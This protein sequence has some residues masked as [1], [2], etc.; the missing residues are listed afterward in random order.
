MTVR[1]DISKIYVGYFG[2]SPEPEGFN[3]WISEANRGFTALETAASFSVQPEST[4]R[5]PYLSN[6]NVADPGPFVDSVY[7]NLFNRDPDPEGR[8]FWIGELNAAQGNPDAV[9]A[10]ILN[11]IS[12]AQNTEEFGPDLDIINNKVKVALDWAESTAEIPGFVYEFGSE[13]ETSAKGVLDDV[14]ETQTSVD[15]G[16]AETDAFIASGAGQPVNTI[17]LTDEIDS[18]SDFVGTSGADQFNATGDT[19]NTGDDLNGGGGADTLSV[20]AGLFQSIVATP[21]LQAIENIEVQGGANN[22]FAQLDLTTSSGVEMAMLN[23]VSGTVQ[24]IGVQDIISANVTNSSTPTPTSP[25]SGTT[26]LSIAYNAAAVAGDADVQ[27]LELENSGLA[28]LSIAG[29]ETV[30]VTATGLNFVAEFD[31]ARELMVDGTGDLIA[32][33]TSADTSSTPTATFDSTAS[34]GNM[35]ISFASGQQVVASAGSGNDNFDLTNTT[36]VNVSGGAGDDIF[37]FDSGNGSLTSEDT[38]DGGEGKDTLAVD[39]DTAAPASIV[40]DVAGMEVLLFQSAFGSLVASEYTQIDEFIFNGGPNNGRVNITGVE[41]DDTFI[42]TSDQGNSDQTLR[43]EGEN[44]G[45]SLSMELHALENGSLTRDFQTV[46]DGNVEVT[47]NTNSGNDVSAIFLAQNIGSVEIASTG[48]NVA[49][50]VIEAI[51]TGSENY[52]AF[53]NDNGTSSFSI[54]GE[55][56]LTIT[57]REGVSL[58]GSSDTLGF[59][60]AVNLDAGAFTGNLRI[61]LSNSADVFEGGSGDDIIYTMGG[62]DRVTGG[63]GSDQFRYSNNSGTDVILDFLIGEDMIGLSEVDFKNTTETTAG[64]TL[65][66][67]DYVENRNGIDNIGSADDFKML[68]LQTGLSADQITNDTGADVEAYVLVYNTTTDKGEIW[69]DND[70]STSGNRDHIATLDNVTDLTG[71]QGFSNTDFVEFIF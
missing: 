24:F 68:E 45:E 71:V 44:V 63:D 14:D 28:S 53:N 59:S 20:Q 60:Q 40:N 26:A 37:F 48:S 5:Y 19:L 9:G 51:D 54:I 2:R 32:S 47:A 50:N 38:V 56:D 43:F 7:Q 34:T 31:Q 30:E 65:N 42:F 35:A 58:T 4:D 61:A 39:N 10:M 62:D 67:E 55:Q 12:G 36:T 1:E 49:A 23:S 8:E 46:T 41:S 64:A 25:N 16:L 57:A 70:W 69:H 18:G 52:Y 3:Y 17:T 33:F 15:Q 29:M 21:R 66:E 27:K 11:I 22:L 13:A 6:P